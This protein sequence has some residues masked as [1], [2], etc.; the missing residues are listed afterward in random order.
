MRR[1]LIW[2]AAALADIEEIEQYIARDSPQNAVAVVEALITAAEG[3]IEFPL[4]GHIIEEL[5]WPGHREVPV[6][7]HRMLYR[8]EESR[9]IIVMV[10]HGARR[11][12]SPS[13]GTR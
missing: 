5:N 11:L 9:V 12:P 4:S 6:K 13:S 3:L 2:S 7:N 8:L 1:R 10:R